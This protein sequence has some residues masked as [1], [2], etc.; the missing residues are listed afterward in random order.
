M[1]LALVRLLSSEKNKIKS[2]L[3]RHL[4]PARARGGGQ[5]RDGASVGTGHKHKK[6][7]AGE[8]TQSQKDNRHKESKKK[9][10]HRAIHR[11]IRRTIQRTKRNQT[12][13]KP[14]QSMKRGLS[15]QL[16][17]AD[18][19]ALKKK[20][21]EKPPSCPSLTRPPTLAAWSPIQL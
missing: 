4:A 21:R 9:N 3:T 2:R 20:V 17:L 14:S 11:T 6:N 8:P 12:K 15:A 7:E 5:R 10:V 13:P 19:K 16:E 18:A 1:L